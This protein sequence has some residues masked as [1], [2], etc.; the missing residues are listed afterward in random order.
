M[1]IRFLMLGKTRRAEVRTLLDDY[2]RRL[3]PYAEVELSEVAPS[4]AAL[5]KVKADPAALWVL[6]DAG[7]KQ[8]TS[9]QLA[10]WLAGLR[11]RGTR[12]V[13]FLCGDD[14]G[15]PAEWRAKA[16]TQLSLS[17]MTLPH[18]LAR[19]VL[20]EQLYRAFTILARHPYHK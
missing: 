13:V 15:F 3:R 8:Y 20:A 12:E 5:R 1:K 7:G 2:L 17:A 10:K 18:E 6:L 9:P 14:A 16:H 11:D 4:P 19:V